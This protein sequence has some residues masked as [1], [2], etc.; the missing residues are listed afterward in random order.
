LPFAV[1]HIAAAIILMLPLILRCHAISPFS[2]HYAASDTHI[3]Y[4]YYCY[5]DALM[6]MLLT[7][8][9]FSISCR[10]LIAA[11]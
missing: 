3:R 10:R 9:L 5:D 11:F 4:Y 2:R 8:L 6:L 1:A 7:P